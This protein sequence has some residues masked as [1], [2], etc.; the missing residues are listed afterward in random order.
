[1]DEPFGVHLDFGY[2]AAGNR[3]TVTDDQGGVV[4]S[5]YDMANRL[6]SRQL[7]GPSADA[8]VDYTYTPLGGGWTR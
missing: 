4:T 6:T 8:R 1:M 5:T 2:D 7:D 3:T